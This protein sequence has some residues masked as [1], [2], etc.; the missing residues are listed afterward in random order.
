MIIIGCDYH[1]GFQQIAFVDTE[2]GE[3]QERRLQHREEAEKFYRELAAQGMK[4][5][6][7]MEASGHARWFERL[8]AEL[9]YELWIGDAAEIRTRRVRKQKTDRQ[10]AQLILKL[11]LKD[12]FPRIWVASWENRDVRQLLWHRH[13]M[14][15]AR[16]RI[17]NQLQAAALNEGRW[18]SNSSRSCRRRLQS[19]ESTD[20]VILA[21]SALEELVKKHKVIP[22]E[23]CPEAAHPGGS[24]TINHC[25]GGTGGCTKTRHQYIGRLKRTY[26]L[27]SRSPTPTVLAVSISLR[28]CSSALES[29]T[30][31]G[32]S[33]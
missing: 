25:Y 22:A 12:D 33:A 14:V 9:Q 3:L 7:G 24:R 26:W 18:S 8:L 20:V 17:M 6:V 30:R 29:P 2:T 4:V 1:P 16:T 21:S 15:Q 27:Q 28:S 10:D 5:R 31:Y 23:K 19:G 32:A 13:R 11:M